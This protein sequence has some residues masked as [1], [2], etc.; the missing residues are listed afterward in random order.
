MRIIYYIIFLQKEGIF[1]ILCDHIKF[2]DKRG[3][4]RYKTIHW[5]TLRK[6]VLQDRKGIHHHHE[7]YQKK[8]YFQEE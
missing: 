1:G 8:I 5:S 3:D 6:N 2:L 4:T 7:N